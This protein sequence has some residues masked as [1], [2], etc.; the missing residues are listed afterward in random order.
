MAS[1]CSAQATASGDPTPTGGTRKGSFWLSGVAC[2]SEGGAAW[3]GPSAPRSHLM[4]HTFQ[5]DGF[6]GYEAGR[7]QPVTEETAC[8]LFHG[9]FSPALSRSAA[10]CNEHCRLCTNALQ[11][12]Q[13]IGQG[14]LAQAR[15]VGRRIRHAHALPRSWPPAPCRWQV[16]CTV[17]CLSHVPAPNWPHAACTQSATGDL[18]RAFFAGRAAF[19]PAASVGGCRGA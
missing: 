14:V 8:L 4:A 18:A 1:G 13:S 12:T 19:T 7:E 15:Q 11:P 2:N 6:V 5:G 9:S 17:A 16:F 10:P 3:L